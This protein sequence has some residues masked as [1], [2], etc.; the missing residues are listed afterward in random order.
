MS[1]KSVFVLS[2][3]LFFSSVIPSLA[4]KNNNAQNTEN[5]RQNIRQEVRDLHQDIQTTRAENRPTI[6][7]QKLES[8]RQ[9]A[10]RVAAKMRLQ[11]TN[12]LTYLDRIKTLLQNKIE[13][14]KNTRD[15]T[16][17]IKELAK[18]DSSPSSK[19]GQALAGFDTLVT[20]ITTLDKPMD[21]IPE[22][23]ASAKTVTDSLKA[24][25]QI[26]TN[27]LRLMVKSPKLSPTP[28]V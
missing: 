27:T 11:F 23:R 22:L 16:A 3:F 9:N 10:Q 2:S 21:I 19:Y 5:L 15:M 18:Y 4:V 8:R 1:T 17:A 12:R 7:Q 14:Q 6:A 13:K 28:T 20:K 24:L 26:L 25:H